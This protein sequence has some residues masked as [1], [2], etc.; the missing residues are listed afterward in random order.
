MNTQLDHD[1]AV[2]RLEEIQEEIRELIHEAATLLP[3]GS[4]IKR[5]ALLYWYPHIK[6]ALIGDGGS[7][8]TL[9][10]SIDEMR[11]AYKEAEG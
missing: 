4:M 5:R 2:R 9:Q 1:V 7:A 11:E 10:D 8:V 3:S 6:V